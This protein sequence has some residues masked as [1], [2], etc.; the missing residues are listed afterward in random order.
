MHPLLRYT[1]L[2]LQSLTIPLTAGLFICAVT[3]ELQ[4]QRLVLEW[5]YLIDSYHPALDVFGLS[6]PGILLYVV[7]ARLLRRPGMRLATFVLL[8]ALTALLC[9]DNFAQTFGN[10]WLPQEVFFELYLA[11][12]HLLGLALLPSLLWWWLLDRLGRRLRPA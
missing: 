5:P 11:Q 1:C 12:L 3:G 9:A 10:T 4:Q 6:L 2:L 7:L 8:T